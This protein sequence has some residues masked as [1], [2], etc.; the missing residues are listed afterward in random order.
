M[1]AATQPPGTADL[2]L[3]AAITAGQVAVD[4][5]LGQIYMQEAGRAWFV[6]HR[7]GAL[8]RAGL[9][10]WVPDGRGGGIFHVTAAGRRTLRDGDRR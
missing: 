3:L 7:V 5:R 10:A 9:L 2:Q 4:T 6:G 1:N 8:I